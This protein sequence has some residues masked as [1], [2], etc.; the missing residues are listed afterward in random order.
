M[1]PAQ[2]LDIYNSGSDFVV[3]TLCDLSKTV[4]SQRGEIETLKIKNAK[5]SKD[6]STSSKKP[7]SD[8]ITKNNGGKPE[9]KDKPGAKKR[10]IGGQPGHER[11]TRV[12]FTEDEIDETHEHVLLACPNCNG[13]THLLDQ[14]PRIIQQIELI[15]VPIVH[16]EH[17]SYPVW[18]ENCQAIH[19]KPFP[20]NVVME[21]L[22]KARL[23][24]TVA[25]LKNVCHA[26]F[27]TI[28]KFIRDV[29]GE[30]VSRG[31]LRKVI[32]KVGHSLDATYAELLDRL[33]YE[34]TVNVDETGHKENR[35]RFWTWVFKAEMYVLFKIDESRGSKVLIEAL[36]KEFNGVIGCDY[37]SAYRKYM[38]DFD[39]TMQFCIAH[40]I[41][42]IR[43]LTT[44]PDKDTKAYGKRI[45]EEVRQLFK[46]IH[47]RYDMSPDQFTDA[48]NAAKSKIMAAALENVPSRLNKAGK[49]TKREAKNMADRFRKHGEAYF[50]FI[51]T[52]EIDPTNNVAEQAIRFIVIDRYVTQ[53]TR[54]IKGR[55]SNERIWTVIATCA[56][57]GRSAFN[58]IL[59]AVTAYF[60]DESAPSLIFDTS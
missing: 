17:I 58:F 30:K 20:K 32:E 52:P 7:S 27:S 28:R 34:N 59:E 44:L 26:S 13:K 48:L 8:D 4:R 36:G 45:L 53:G 54:S 22:F 56:L 40:L 57:Q 51:T 24:A 12:P 33:P 15:E 39:V 9:T 6:S 18:C 43:F 38:K 49:E 25:Y 14:P 42:D 21:G 16:H 5:L 23:T 19:Y 37:F 31:Y 29:L 50:E 1:T 10:K 46:V 11:H 55:K 60:N 2:A 47:S 35:K 41:R 3:S